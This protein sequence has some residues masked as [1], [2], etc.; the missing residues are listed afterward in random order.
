MIF[1]PYIA[2]AVLVAVLFSHGWAFNQGK[3]F[4]K[5]REASRIEAVNKRIREVNAR[6]EATA[7]KERELRDDAYSEVSSVL[8]RSGKCFVTPDVA[9]ALSRIR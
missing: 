1:N 7:A 9:D 2:G 6:E 5:R 3:A 4:E 8:L